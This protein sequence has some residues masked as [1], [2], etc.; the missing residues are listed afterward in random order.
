MLLQEYKRHKITI[1]NSKDKCINISV[2]L[3]ETIFK[4]HLFSNIVCNE[5]KDQC[6]GNAFLHHIKLG[7]A[8]LILA[9]YISF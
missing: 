6:S 5:I 1:V 3:N 2:Q 9:S 7:I 8:Y 4:V